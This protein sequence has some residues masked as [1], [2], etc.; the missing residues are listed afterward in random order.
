MLTK[1]PRILL[2]PLGDAVSYKG[3]TARA[4]E[5]YMRNPSADTYDVLLTV[6]SENKQSLADMFYSILRK[7]PSELTY[8]HATTSFWNERRLLEAGL[9]CEKIK[10]YLPDDVSVMRMSALIAGNRGDVEKLKHEIGEIQRISPSNSSLAMLYCLFYFINNEYSM[11]CFY[12]EE[13]LH[14]LPSDRDSFAARLAVD[15]ALK[16]ANGTL[17]SRAILLNGSDI[18]RAQNQ[19]ALS[20]LKRHLIELLR[21]R[22]IAEGQAHV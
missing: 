1:I 6:T 8:R 19:D 10:G 9:C 14:V 7:K 2:E 13:A 5:Q 11:A 15:V 18:G 12:A 22:Q 20:L 17:L 16:A 4:V 21:R 3:A